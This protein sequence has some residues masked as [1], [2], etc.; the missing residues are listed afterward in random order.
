ME[1]RKIIL[2]VGLVVLCAALSAS[3]TVKEIVAPMTQTICMIYD[4]MKNMAGGLAALVITIAGFK[5]VGSAEDPGARKQAKDTIIHAIIG[6]LLIS[7]ATDLVKLIT[8]ST[9]CS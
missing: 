4:V 8:G 5:W 2:A 7:V 9:G 1:R 3:G 6:M